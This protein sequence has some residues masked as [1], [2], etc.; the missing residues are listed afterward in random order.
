[1]AMRRTLQNEG[2]QKRRFIRK[3]RKL[4]TKCRKRPAEYIRISKDG[5]IRVGARRDHDLCGQ[6]HRSLAQSIAQNF[7]ARYL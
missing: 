5:K 1:M 7:Y 2:W 4:C 6:C 3:N